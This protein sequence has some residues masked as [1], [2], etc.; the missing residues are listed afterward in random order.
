MRSSNWRPAVVALLTAAILST[1]MAIAQAPRRPMRRY[2]SS[3]NEPFVSP[4]LNMAR[5]GADPSFNYT[6]LVQPQLTQQRNTQIQAN[7][8]QT[9]NR[10]VQ[11]Q[12]ALG[13]YGAVGGMR[14]TG[15]RAASYGNYSHFYPSRGAGASGGKAARNYPSPSA[16]GSGFGVY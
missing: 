1:S 3:T 7:Q 6:T 4:Y 14:A 15:G 10:D 2:Q 13:A 12:G 5:P 11:Q 16:G 9:L 8:L